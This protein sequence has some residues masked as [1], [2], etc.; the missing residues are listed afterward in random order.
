[1]AKQRYRWK[2]GSL[3][4]LIKYRGMVM[5][6]SRRYTGTLT[7]YRMPMA[8][9]S[10]FTL[11]VSPLAWTY[12]A[13]WSLATQTPALV[14]G[15]YATITAYT[16]LTI[17]MDENLT[18]RERARLSIYAPTAYFLFYIMDL[19]QLT[20]AVR[21]IARS[22]GLIWRPEINTWKSPQRAATLVIARAA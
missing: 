21:C 9:L 6:P 12:A 17:W 8:V 15:A 19:V 1:L 11:L 4:N 10:E 22:R 16:L 13:Y 2:F 7:Y 20:A 5:N 3:Q 14:L 18:V